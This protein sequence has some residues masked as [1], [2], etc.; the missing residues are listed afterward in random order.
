MTGEV[1]SVAG[2]DGLQANGSYGSSGDAVKVRVDRVSKHFAAVSG[3]GKVHVVL[4]ELSLDIKPGEFVSLIGPSGCG[5]STL[6]EIIAGL[7][8]STSGDVLLDG[9]AITGPGPDRPVV[10]QEYALFPWRTVLDNVAFPLEVAKVRKTERYDQA[11]ARLEEV[12]LGSFADHY[13]SQL[14]GGMRQRAAIARALVRDPDVLLMDE[15][16]GAL[17][18]ITRELL[19]EQL[20]ALHK[21]ERKTII[22]VTHSVPEAI[23]LSNRIIVMG[24]APARLVG[25]FELAEQGEANQA[26]FISRETAYADVRDAIWGL[27]REHGAIASRGT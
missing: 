11:R 9:R 7:Q 16:F 5:K 26:N 6:L 2:G 23:R 24:I 22:F 10:F 13:P 25:V 8:A 12:G 3:E 17:D 15:P 21:L 27:L 19:Q 20:R 1:P 18:A 14:S 4:D